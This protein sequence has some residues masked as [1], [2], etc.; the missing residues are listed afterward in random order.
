MARNIGNIIEKIIALVYVLVLLYITM[1]A[2][3]R[4]TGMFG[5]DNINLKPFSDKWFYI[6]NF[7]TLKRNQRWF[8]IKEMGGNLLLLVPF[9]WFYHTVVKNKIG[10]VKMGLIIVLTALCIENLQ[11]WLHIGTF[12]IDDIILN[13]T[14]G[15][16]GVFL[17]EILRKR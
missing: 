14:G 15:F 12:D 4:Y 11:Y 2:P 17:F 13:I 8:I 6:E 1:M 3:N 9:A 5:M 10:R 16:V 7:Q